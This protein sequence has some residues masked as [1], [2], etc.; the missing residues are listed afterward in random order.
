MVILGHDLSSPTTCA[1]H[2]NSLDPPVVSLP[3][4]RLAGRSS[5]QAPHGLILR[6]PPMVYQVLTPCIGH[7][8]P[9]ERFR[10][11]TH[12]LHNRSCF[13]PV[14]V[15]ERALLQFK[16]QLLEAHYRK[17]IHKIGERAFRWD[18]DKKLGDAVEVARANAMREVWE[19][20]EGEQESVERV[21]IPAR[22][23]VE[24]T[25]C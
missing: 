12:L 15:A 25:T 23:A 14:H 3:R 7:A 22:L 20:G 16:V 1:R 6:D 13:F 10:Q 2:L 5:V 18:G 24:L 8:H 4:Y 19:V 21:V 11:L 17:G 9:F